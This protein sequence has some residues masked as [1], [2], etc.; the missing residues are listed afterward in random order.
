MESRRPFPD[1][2]AVVRESGCRIRRFCSLCGCTLLGACSTREEPNTDQPHLRNLRH[3]AATEPVVSESNVDF[4]GAAAGMGPG[5]ATVPQRRR[6]M[7]QS[8]GRRPRQLLKPI[9]RGLHYPKPGGSGALGPGSGYRWVGRVRTR[10]PAPWVNLP[11]APRKRRP[12][13]TL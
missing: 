11:K 12:L 4:R 2:G 7:R 6:L 9:Q 10:H 13:A 5:V 1:S 8:N 3:G